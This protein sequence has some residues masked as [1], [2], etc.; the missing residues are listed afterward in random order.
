MH[1][2]WT[3]C[4]KS[5]LS[6]SHAIGRGRL[7]EGEAVW[8]RFQ[9]WIKKD[10]VTRCSGSISLCFRTAMWPAALCFCLPDGPYPHTVTQSHLSSWSRFCQAFCHN[11]KRNWCTHHDMQLYRKPQWHVTNCNELDHPNAW[12]NMNLSLYEN[13]SIVMESLAT[14]LQALRI[15]ILL[16]TK[17]RHHCIK[18]SD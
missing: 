16:D 6:H 7:C 11:L 2:E 1:Y 8:R 9:S 17:S 15:N 4:N 10:R 14:Q 13:I 5:N 12:A 3:L 18:S